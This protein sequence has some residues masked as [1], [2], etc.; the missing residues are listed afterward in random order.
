VNWKIKVKQK[1]WHSAAA[2][3]I[4]NLAGNP[5]TIEAAISLIADRLLDGVLC[6][7]TDLETIKNRLN[8]RAFEPVKGLPIA[9][10][11]RKDGDG[12]KIVYSNSLSQGR[13]RFT[14]AHE[15]AHAVFETTGP[16]CPRYGREL[17]RLCDMLASELLLPT[18]TVLK[19]VGTYVNPTKISDLARTFQTSLM[20]TALR[21]YQLYA[22]SVFQMD[23]GK[24]A[25]GY[26]TV[27][28]QW[29]LRT[30]PSGF[31]SA[32]AQAMSG[33]SGKQVVF[34]RGGQQMLE[35][36][37]IHGQRRALFVLCPNNGRLIRATR[38]APKD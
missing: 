19:E 15:L 20:A 33:I 6:P 8:V 24:V 34:V 27:R 38:Q 7:P 26:G 21:F 13:R 4:S 10:E 37:P 23:D 9:G 1:R 35:W 17:E 12:F 14:L 25:W 32:I 29:N 5:Q 28:S 16:N 36:T 2:R 11:L 22:I 18:K 31:R 30:D 3:R